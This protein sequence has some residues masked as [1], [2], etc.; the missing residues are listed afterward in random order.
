MDKELSDADFIG[1]L[2]RAGILKLVVMTKNLEGFRDDKGLRHLVRHWSPSFH[3]FFFFVGELIVN[4]E[5]VEN[6]FLP[7][8]FGNKSPFN[9]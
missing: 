4:L 5:D 3:T 2:E 8:M 1:C 9:I 6:T 7:P